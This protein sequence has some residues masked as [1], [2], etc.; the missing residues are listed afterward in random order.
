M[1][2]AIER[3]VFGRLSVCLCHMQGNK[4]CVVVVDKE[5]YR[6]FFWRECIVKAVENY[7]NGLSAN[8]FVFVCIGL[9]AIRDILHKYL[10]AFTFS[11]FSE[12]A[13]HICRN[14]ASVSYTSVGCTVYDAR[15]SNRSTALTYYPYLN[16]QTKQVGHQIGLE[17]CSIHK[18]MKGNVWRIK[19]VKRVSVKPK[20]TSWNFWNISWN[21]SRNISWNISRQKI[22]WNFTSL[23]VT[24]ERSIIQIGAWGRPV[25]IILRGIRYTRLL[26][27]HTVSTVAR[28]MSCVDRCAVN[29]IALWICGFSCSLAAC[30]ESM[31]VASGQ[32]SLQKVVSLGCSG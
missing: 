31:Q 13:S 15:H 27:W 29:Y 22:S 26:I 20:K 2:C 25:A 21:I 5:K 19:N 11:G 9:Y 7:K 3:Y 18:W 32:T 12:N 16:K 10:I 6:R 1:L 8:L 23:L 4:R 17:S 24:Q 28:A 30:V 14:L